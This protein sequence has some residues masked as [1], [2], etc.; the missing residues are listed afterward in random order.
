[1]P[2]S[3]YKKFLT[4]WRRLV[5]VL[6]DLCVLLT[7]YF[8]AF[9][10]RFE[11]QLGPD[12]LRILAETFLY[13][14]SAFYACA[15][16]FSLYRGLYAYSSFSDL[17]NIAKTL[18]LAGLLS[19]SAILFVRQGQFPRSIL[20]LAP[21]LNF[22][23]ICGVRS[24]IRLVKHRLRMR[25]VMVGDGNNVLLVGAGELGES[26]LRQILKTPEPN[27]QVV[28]FIDDDAAK[29]GMRIHGYPVLGGRGALPEILRKHEIDEIFIAIAMQRGTI[30]RS[31]TESVRNSAPDRRPEIKIAPSLEEMLRTPGKDFALRA[32]KPAD[33]LNRSV[34]RLDEPRIAKSLERKV[35]L[36]T[37]AGGTIGSELCEQILKFK[38]EKVVLLESHATSL[39]FAESRLKELSRGTAIAP[40][41]GDIRDRGLVERVFK[42]HRPHVVLHAAAHKHVHQ[43]EFNVNE[44]ISNNLLGT[45]YAAQAADKYGSEAFLLVSTD[46]AVRPASVMGATKR[47]AERVIQHWAR[48]SA[49]RYCAVR[50]GNV[51]GS[52]GSVL[53]IFEAQIAGGGPVTVTDPRATRYFMTVQEAVGLILQAV[54][55][56]RGGEIFVLKMGTPV[57]IIDMARNLI[58]LSGLEPDKDI[59]IRITGL[60]Q[61]E[62]LDEEIT[63]DPSDLSQSAHPDISLVSGQRE[64]TPD[65][66][67]C[68]LDF[69]LLSRGADSSNLLKRL[70]DFVPSFEPSAGLL[71]PKA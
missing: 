42:T 2:Q 18:T 14:L 10:L 66:D 38:P 5:V 46:K 4:N 62:K 37:G 13:S 9:L 52:S 8:L 24:G 21:I 48:K 58:V 60:K 28:G 25:G 29:W 61:G 44:G 3:P 41:L 6:L 20:I 47:A 31:I 19:A 54:S 68:I 65:L 55:I 1:M 36:V 39:F 34:V 63:D 23:G 16:F 57:K 7:A 69:E 26:L 59:E 43:L 12:E 64:D 67:A 33:L 51:L 30:V 22:L 15:Y 71:D 35:I 56:S 32:V 11:F 49:C 40:V 53:P 70:R 50:F 45:H 17:L 27:Y